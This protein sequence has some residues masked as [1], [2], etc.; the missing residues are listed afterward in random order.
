MPRAASLQAFD[1]PSRPGVRCS[2]ATSAKPVGAPC[3]RPVQRV[4]DLEIALA[5]AVFRERAR[6]SSAGVATAEQPVVELGRRDRAD[7]ALRRARSVSPEAS[8][9]PVARPSVCDDRGNVGAGADLAAALLDQRLERREQVRRAA[10]DDRRAGRLQRK[11]DDLGDLA[12]EGV[13]RAEPGMQHPRRPQRARQSPIDRRF[14]ASRAPASA[15]RRG[16]RQA[17]AARAARPRRPAA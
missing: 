17:R 4:V 10:L 5:V 11:G 7:H 2:S 8:R 1:T 3:R 13:F 6:R 15:P 14:P 9:T 16:R 12:G